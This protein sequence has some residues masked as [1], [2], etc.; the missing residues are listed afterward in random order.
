M[1]NEDAACFAG[2]LIDEFGAARIAEA[3]D[4]EFEE[5]MRSATRA[6]RRSVVDTMLG[7]ANFGALFT[8]QFSGAISAESAS[9]LADSFLGS[10]GFRDAL[11]DSSASGD[12]AFDDPD[13]QAELLPAMLDCL[14]AEELIQ[15][16]QT[17]G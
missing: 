15:L 13:L 2:G 4:L 5:F 16:G 6:E 10:D 11:A 17:D 8:Q 9:C 7:C 1:S 3:I 12:S 14:S